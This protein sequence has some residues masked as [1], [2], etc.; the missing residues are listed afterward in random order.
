MADRGWWI[1]RVGG[2]LLLNVYANNIIYKNIITQTVTIAGDDTP[3]S[4]DIPVRNHNCAIRFYQRPRAIDPGRVNHNNR[5]A[6]DCI[7]QC[8]LFSLVL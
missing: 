4:P 6:I 5:Q 8:Y 7:F 3:F 1:T 2:E